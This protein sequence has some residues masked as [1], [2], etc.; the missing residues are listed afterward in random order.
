MAIEKDCP[1][2][3]AEAEDEEKRLDVFVDSRSLAD[4]LLQ[5][6]GQSVLGADQTHGQQRVI[7]AR[8]PSQ[9]PHKLSENHLI[10]CGRR[11]TRLDIVVVDEHEL[12]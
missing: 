4:K 2:R 11:H 6:F 3:V 7:A 12:D 9:F 1:G 10:T 5:C 8:D